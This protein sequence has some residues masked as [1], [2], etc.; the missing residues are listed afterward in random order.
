M[1]DL[2][3]PDSSHLPC[4]CG[5]CCEAFLVEASAADALREPRIAAL[6]APVY[7]QGVADGE[8]IE[9]GAPVGYVLNRGGGPS[10]PCLLLERDSQ[11]RGVCTIYPTRPDICRRFDCEGAGGR[12]LVALGYAVDHRPGRSA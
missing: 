12:R 9:A 6:G 11:G 1:E 4:R 2:A 3:L 7:R 8:A 5:L 10:G